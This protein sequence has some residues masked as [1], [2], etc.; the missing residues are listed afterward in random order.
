LI[1][2]IRLPNGRI[3]PKTKMGFSN[4]QTDIVSKLYDSDNNLQNFILFCLDNDYIPLFELVSF[5]N[6]IVLN[7]DDGKV[8]LLKIRSNI[9]GDYIDLNYFSDA[10]YNLDN[11]SVV[12]SEE[13]NSIDEILALTKTLTNK[14]GWVVNLNRDGE[15]YFIKI[16][17]EWYYKMHNLMTEQL[18]RENDI[19][20]LIIKNQIDD[21][22]S[23]LDSV[24][25]KNKIE[26][27]NTIT[28]KLTKFINEYY[29]KIVKLYEVFD[30]EYCSDRKE[31]VNDYRKHKY[32]YF[33]ML[34]INGRN[35][36][37]II[38]EFILK[39]CYRLKDAREFLDKI[40]L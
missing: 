10:V 28:N 31:F 18:E 40:P 13:F 20:A 29:T 8:V 15:E 12:K 6:R 9:T 36:Y 1:S 19:I 14:E 24:N 5:R 39:K 33:V 16:K 17:T 23:Q 11:I 34:Y 25:D 7:Y 22:I 37:D 3:I 2:F 35:I 32:F 27:I 38:N 26:F 30:K 4:E 21:I